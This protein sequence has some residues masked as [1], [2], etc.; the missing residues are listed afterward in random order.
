M[1]LV[2]SDEDRA[3]AQKM[4]T[5][6]T[7][8]IPEDIRRRAFTGENAGKDDMVATQRIL[9]AHGYAV[10][11]WPIEWGGQDWTPMQRHLW[12]EEMQLACVPQ[13]LAFNASMVGPVIAAF[14]NEEQ[15]KRF[16]PAT[17]NLDIWWCQG[18]SEPNAGSDLA[19]L[20]TAAVRDGD[21]YVVNGQKTW[22]TLAQYADWIFCL[23]R[24]NPDVKKQAGISFLLI[25]MKTPGITVRP[26]QLID[27]GHEVNEVFFDNVVV[28]AENLVGE[29]NAG[30]SYAK[31]LLGNER[32]GIARLGTSKVKAARVKALAAKTRVG[33]GT[34]LDDPLFAARLARVEIEI[35]A[36]EMTQMRILSSQ[37]KG[38]EAPDPRSSVLKLKGSAIQQDLT[39][40]LIDV[41]GEEAAAF[42]EDTDVPDGFAPTTEGVID[43]MPTYFNYRKVTIYGGSS[44]VQRSII[45]KAILGF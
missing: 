40:L 45:S 42:R 4:R 39:E 11:N 8:E 32:T 44:E 37:T 6:F 20:K 9:N 21:S 1:D 23:V 22:T 34:L 10:P 38:D 24:T 7:T 12:L 25:D 13:P 33:D 29:E 19:S 36:L 30:W 2:L 18:F 41:V 28:P 17:A 27:G 31:F 26:I 14:G 15:K 43:A 5:F 35:A 3:F 16:L